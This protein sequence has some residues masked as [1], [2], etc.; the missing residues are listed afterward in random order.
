MATPP[1]D[2]TPNAAGPAPTHRTV[3]CP[4]CGGDSLYSPSNAYRPFCSKR[5]KQVDLGAWASEDFR[6]PAEAPPQDAQ[7]GDPRTEH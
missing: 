1:P 2:T 3:V 5:C 6:M 4:T 7:Y